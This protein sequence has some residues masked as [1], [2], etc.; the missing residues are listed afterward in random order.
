MPPMMTG[1]ACSQ[2]IDGVLVPK[3]GG[4]GTLLNDLSKLP[5]KPHLAHFT[6]GGNNAKEVGEFYHHSLSNMH[7]RE[8]PR[9]IL[10]WHFVPSCFVPVLFCTQHT[11]LNE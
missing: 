4:L 10:F 9:G 11:F 7:A 3:G 5:P 1:V 8:S 6:T 2:V